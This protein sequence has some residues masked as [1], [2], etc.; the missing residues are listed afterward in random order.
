MGLD[1]ST[2]VTVIKASDGKSVPVD[3]LDHAFAYV[4]GTLSTDTVVFEGV[5]YVQTYTYTAGALTG[6]SKWVKQ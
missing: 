4:N 5:T 6:M 3:S 2:E 1:T